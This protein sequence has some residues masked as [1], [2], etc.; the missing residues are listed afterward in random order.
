MADTTRHRVIALQNSVDGLAGTKGVGSF[1]FDPR[2]FG[3]FTPKQII[4]DAVL[5]ASDGALTATVRLVNINDD[6]TITGTTLNTSST[7]PVILSSSPLD[8]ADLAGF[9]RRSARSYEVQILTSGSAD[10]E[11]TF[12]GSAHLRIIL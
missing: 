2:D 4:L 3:G 1:R 7:D 9:F 12:L 5:S 11:I 8:V 10:T 6:E